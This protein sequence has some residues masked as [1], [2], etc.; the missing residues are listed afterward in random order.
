M[1]AASGPVRSKPTHYI[2]LPITNHGFV[3]N[4]ARMQL[5]MCMKIPELLSVIEDPDGLHCTILV[6]DLSNPDDLK[7]VKDFMMFA[8][9][10][11][12]VFNSLP[13]RQ[14][15]DV[16]SFDDDDDDRVAWIKPG[17]TSFQ[18][19]TIIQFQRLTRKLICQPATRAWTP[20]VSLARKRKGGTIGVS[21]DEWP[22]DYLFQPL[23]Y[24]KM[25]LRELGSHEENP[26]LTVCFNSM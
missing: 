12:R 24:K 15:T 13:G 3:D 21:A 7:L 14:K 1:A 6:L 18:M 11:F 20:H 23:S 5:E 8:K 9:P 19:E 10:A 16:Q 22:K 4:V 2:S 25:E 17:F 26:V